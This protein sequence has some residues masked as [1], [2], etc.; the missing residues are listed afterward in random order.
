M[1]FYLIK[2]DIFITAAITTAVAA[3]ALISPNVCH[4]YRCEV[5]KWSNRK[6]TMTITKIFL[7]SPMKICPIINL[8]WLTS[9][10]WGN[11]SSSRIASVLGA[12]L[13]IQCKQ[14][15]GNVEEQEKKVKWIFSRALQWNSFPVFRIWWCC[16][17]EFQK[18]ISM[19]IRSNLC[20]KLV[21]HNN[22][23]RGEQCHSIRPLCCCC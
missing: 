19:Q 10:R 6:R 4:F 3:V 21:G 18:S 8:F 9:K 12:R 23:A 5:G 20:L 15:R 22:L 11:G 2:T 16:K 14:N 7:T 1:H 13:G 17:K